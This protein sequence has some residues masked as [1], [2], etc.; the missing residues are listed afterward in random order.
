MRRNGCRAM[1]KAIG[2]RDSHDAAVRA[3]S[4]VLVY[5]TDAGLIFRVG[6]S[7]AC[8]LRLQPAGRRESAVTRCKAHALRA[9]ESTCDART[10]GALAE[11]ARQRASI[12]TDESLPERPA[13]PGQPRIHCHPAALHPSPHTAP[14]PIPLLE[15]RAYLLVYPATREHRAVRGLELRASPDRGDQDSWP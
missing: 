4:R 15:S 8:L 12:G 7:R 11:R 1:R 14:M 9:I 10:A 6:R 2:S 5:R 13:S 3:S